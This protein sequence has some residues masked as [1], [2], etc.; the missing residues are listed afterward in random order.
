MLPELTIECGLA[1]YLVTLR[2][3]EGRQQATVECDMF[4]DIPSLLEGLLAR[5]KAPWKAFRSY[6]EKAKKS[7]DGT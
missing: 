5:G 6:R 2:D 7:K 1:C 4:R 3:H